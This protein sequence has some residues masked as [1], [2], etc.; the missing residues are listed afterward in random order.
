MHTGTHVCTLKHAH[1]CTHMH[2]VGTLVQ[3]QLLAKSILDAEDCIRG[4]T[5]APRHQSL[6]IELWYA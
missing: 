5:T 4:K 2:A 3:Q 6:L 1:I